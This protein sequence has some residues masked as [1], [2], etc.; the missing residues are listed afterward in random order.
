GKLLLYHGWNDPAI[1]ATNSIDY[2]NSVV[3]ALGPADT[4]STIRFFLAPGVQHCA[5]GPGPDAFGQSGM[6]G[7]SD[8]AHDAQLALQEWVEKGTV[9]AEIIATKYVGE[10]DKTVKMTR[11]LCAYPRVARYKGT[12]SSDDAAN[13]WCAQKQ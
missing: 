13:F 4:D 11:P 12:G 1:S 6:A 3:T 2:Y 5:G 8:V 9:P 10:G 7:P